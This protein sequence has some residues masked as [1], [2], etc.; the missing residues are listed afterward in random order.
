MVCSKSGTGIYA[1][2][3]H[4]Y[5]IKPNDI[6]I[7]RSNEIHK[8]SKIET[9]TDATLMNIQFDTTL[10]WEYDSSFF[11]SDWTGLFLNNSSDFCNRIDRNNPYHDTILKLLIEIKNET[12]QK[13]RKYPLMV[14]IKLLN[15]FI[16]LLRHFNYAIEKDS[17]SFYQYNINAIKASID[18]IYKHLTEK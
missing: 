6:F 8:I 2:E 7:F 4:K 11:D 9:E 13:S 15:I 17:L 10:L 5:S 12:Q 1:T 16:L 14:R 3:T 18:Y